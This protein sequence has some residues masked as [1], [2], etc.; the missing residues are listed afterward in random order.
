M[1]QN[2]KSPHYSQTNQLK[3]M[4]VITVT[5]ITFTCIFNSLTSQNIVPTHPRLLVNMAIRAKLIAKKEANV[6]EWLALSTEAY[7]YANKSIMAWTPETQNTW[8]TDYIFYS[9][10]GSSWEEATMALAMAH[11]VNKPVGAGAVPSIFTYKLID[12]A[13]SITAAYNRSPNTV[14]GNPLSINSYYTTRHLGYTLGIIYDWC[15]DE[16]G[17]TRRTKIINLMNAMYDEMRSKAYQRKERATGN[18]FFGHALCAAMWGYAT[19]GDNPRAAEMIAYAKRRYDGTTS[20]LLTGGDDNPDSDMLQTFNGG[21]KPYI[22]T[23]YNGIPS[24]SGAPNK[25]GLQIQG[26]GYGADNFARV[27]DYMQVVKTATGVDEPANQQGILTQLLR[28]MKHA[29]L[30]RQ[31]EIDGYSDW[32]GNIANYVPLALPHRLAALLEGTSSGPNAQRFAYSDIQPAYLW[33]K[34]VWDL[35]NWEKMLFVDAKRPSAPMIE[36]LYYS[37]FNQGYNLG[38]GNGA[39]PYFI[40]RSDWGTNATW[41]S[42]NAASSNYDDHQHFMAGAPTIKHGDD[43]LLVNASS[44]HDGYPN[45]LTGNATLAENSG[46]KSTLFFND[47]FE[48]QQNTPSAI[49]GQSYYGKDDLKVV[50][51]NNDYTYIRSDF[52]SCYNRSG[53]ISTY[54]NKCLYKYYRDFVYLRGADVFLTSDF[55]SARAATPQYRKHIRWHFPDNQPIVAGNKI[56]STFGNSKLAITTLVPAA[57]SITAVNQSANP[58][59]SFGT[60]LNYYFNSKTWRAEVAYPTTQPDEEYLTVLQPNF[61]S[62]TDAAV[63]FIATNDTKMHGAKIVLPNGKTEFVLLNRNQ[64]ALQTPVLSTAYTISGSCSGQHTLFGMQPFAPYQ[65]SIVGNTVFVSQQTGGTATATSAGV[66]RFTPCVIPI[67]L[68]SFSGKTDGKMNV[69]TWQTAS[70]IGVS[71]FELERSLDGKQFEKIN[72]V[73]AKN[74]PSVYQ[75]FDNAVSKTIYYRLKTVDLDAKIAFSNIITLENSEILRG[76]KIYPNPVSDVLNIENAEGKDI[77]IVNALGQVVLSIKANNQSTIN[78]NQLK[79][80]VYFVKMGDEMVRF[81]KK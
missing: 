61:N 17:A 63:S 65:I 10:C 75:L 38:G 57:P 80:G 69:L 7:N 47:N 67:E 21:Y 51:I 20:P 34:T 59:N 22:A 74:T 62:A 66:L 77:E 37:G 6:A 8:N 29:L 55:V 78:I 72:Q 16:L 54:I 36:P 71:H 14:W 68:L 39:F 13:D 79:N 33:G 5:L 56:T 25:G 30:P 9:Y 64:N 46:S 48:F 24:V 26:W 12:L 28:G 41:A 70:E 18:Y 50:E 60:N 43:Y 4:K 73:A 52:T 23:A 53:D 35:S 58:D 76:I 11:L 32:G 31:Y 40:M 15:Y 44:W 19:Y 49:G 1:C 42:Y 27:L 2:F 45:G 81:V 3:F